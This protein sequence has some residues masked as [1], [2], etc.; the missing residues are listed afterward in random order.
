MITLTYLTG[1][2]VRYSNGTTAFQVFSEQ[3][4]DNIRLLALPKEE[5]SISTISWPGEYDFAGIAIT[6]IGHNEGASVSYILSYDN[7]K[8]AFL[9]APLH[10]WSD[11]DLELLGDIDVLVLPAG[12]AKIVQKLID[13]IDPRVLV[14]TPGTT[15]ELVPDVLKAVGAIGKEAQAEYKLKGSLPVEG[16]EIVVFG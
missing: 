3:A 7:V 10:A 1:A 5:P 9:A 4:T 8:T 12:D 15:P 2:G 11:H 16:R 14:V 6:G 13:E